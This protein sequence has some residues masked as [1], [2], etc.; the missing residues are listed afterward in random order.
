MMIVKIFH[1]Y[2][3]R[4]RVAFR[5]L[6]CTLNFNDVNICV[7]IL[8]R[9]KNVNALLEC[10]RATPQIF[11][12]SYLRFVVSYFFLLLSFRSFVAFNFVTILA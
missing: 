12:T 4:L 2:S 7:V 1:G 10:G 5:K 3:S 9:K 11:A 8:Y 6:F